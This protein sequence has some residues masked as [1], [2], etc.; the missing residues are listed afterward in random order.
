MS[1]YEK[2]GRWHFPGANVPLC[3][4]F[5]RAGLRPTRCW[6]LG[7]ET[8][9]WNTAVSWGTLGKLLTATENINSIPAPSFH[10]GVLVFRQKLKSSEWTFTT[11]FQWGNKTEREHTINKAGFCTQK[12]VWLFTVADI[13]PLT[14]DTLLMCPYIKKWLPGGWLGG[15][16]VKRKI[17]LQFN[18]SFK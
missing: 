10:T 5:H 12:L 14:K 11:H 9:M 8:A 2:D 18:R 3:F 17:W 7:T 1:F 16:K 6:Q 13:C 15:I 4:Q